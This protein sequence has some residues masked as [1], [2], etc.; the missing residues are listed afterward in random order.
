MTAQSVHVASAVA[1]AA[2]DSY[3]PAGHDDTGWEQFVPTDD[4]EEMP[5]NG[6]GEKEPVPAHVVHT[7]SD[8]AFAAAE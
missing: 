3:L 2:T 7:T 4:A 6:S 5:V 1:V 8:V